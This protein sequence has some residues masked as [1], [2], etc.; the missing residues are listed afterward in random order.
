MGEKE[1]EMHK[2]LSK[3][4]KLEQQA[5]TAFE[6]GMLECRI[7]R[8][9][10]KQSSKRQQEETA[11]ALREVTDKSGDASLK[12]LVVIHEANKAARDALQTSEYW[13]GNLPI[14]WTTMKGLLDSTDAIEEAVAKV[15]AQHK[16]KQ[17]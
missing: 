9:E 1:Q 11:K 13:W 14:A 3:K 8:L 17:E 16:L 2:L 5:G 6:V 7:E 10:K 4:R 15:V 12:Q